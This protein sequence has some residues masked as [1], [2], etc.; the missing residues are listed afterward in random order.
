YTALINVHTASER[1]MPPALGVVYR[2]AA[3]EPYTSQMVVAPNEPGDYELRLMFTLPETTTDF[4]LR[5]YDQNVIGSPTSWWDELTVVE[6]DYY[7]TPFDGASVDMGGQ[8][9]YKWEGAVNASPS[10]FHEA[11][12]VG[13]TKVV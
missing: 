13:V 11:T 9:L 5:A 4:Y 8:G 6:G 1:A 3:G 7:G 10:A 12:R 2:S